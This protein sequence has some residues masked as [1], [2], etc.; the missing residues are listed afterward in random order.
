MLF[1]KML[2]DFQEEFWSIFLSISVIGTG[3]DIILHL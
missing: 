3:N 1:R 2:R